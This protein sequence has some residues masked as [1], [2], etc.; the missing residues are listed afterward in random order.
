MIALQAVAL[1]L[2]YG[3]HLDVFSRRLAAGVAGDVALIAALVR[4]EPPEE[5]GWIFR[6]A[7]W[8]LGLSF[9]LEEGARLQPV[10]RPASL[11]LLPLEEDLDRAL[12]ERLRL[13]FDTDWQSDTSSVII[14][15][16]LP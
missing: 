12:E 15:V 10:D 1:Q 11:P 7:A 3:G 9:A 8:R 5:R 14:R 4:R 2:F 6:E 16:Q 13:P